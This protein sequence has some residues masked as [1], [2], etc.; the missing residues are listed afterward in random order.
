MTI[1]A[2]PTSRTPIRRD[3]LVFVSTLAIVVVGVSIPRVVPLERWTS[4]WLIFAT[5][6]AVGLAI[7]GIAAGCDRAAL[8]LTL[9]T[10]QGAWYWVRAATLI[11]ATVALAC[12]G[13]IAAARAGHDW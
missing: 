11:G 2:A 5:S 1:L 10:R 6:G 8:G 9:R 12:A 7:L 3:V 13:T 4:P